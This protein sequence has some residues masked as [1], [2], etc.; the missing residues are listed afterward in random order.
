MSIPTAHAD[1][2]IVRYFTPHKIRA[3]RLADPFIMRNSMLQP[4]RPRSLAFLLL[5]AL[6]LPFRSAAAHPRLV[7][8]VPAAESHVQTMPRALSVTFNESLTIALS[9]L[10]LLD[11][12]GQPVALDTVR[13]ASED[14]KTL[15]ASILGTMPAGRYTV[16][17]QA[18]GADGHPMRGQYTFV[19]DAAPVESTKRTTDTGTLKGGASSTLRGT[20]RP[21]VPGVR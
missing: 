15:T 2:A 21:R 9:R 4:C 16:K 6:V 5:L 20:S 3:A 11:P 14:T 10:T 18:A 17:W 19:L 12:T 1:G 7:R 8:A 13:F